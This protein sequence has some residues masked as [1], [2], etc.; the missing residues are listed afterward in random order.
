MFERLREDVANVLDKD[1]AARSA[2]EVLL[3][4]PGIHAV[5][6]HR[7]ANAL[8]RAGF[9]T[10]ARWVSHLGRF[11]TGIEIHPE[12][13]IQYLMKDTASKNKEGRVRAHPFVTADDFYDEGKY[14]EL[15]RNAA[16]EVLG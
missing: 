3:C 13:K 12:E 2:L 1:P 14:G 6:V 4:Y 5:V 10:P 7:L 8:W 16:E 15:L 11:V 9:K